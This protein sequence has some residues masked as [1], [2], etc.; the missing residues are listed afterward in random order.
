MSVACAV[1]EALE[2]SRGHKEQADLTAAQIEH[3]MPQKLREEW[4]AALGE[5][6]ARIHADWLHRPGN[7]TLSAYNQEVGNQPYAAKR[8]RF[9]ES[10]VVLTRELGQS[11]N[12]GE[13]EIRSRGEQLA[14]E[15][16]AI[17]VGPVEPYVPSET[18]DAANDY[19]AQRFAFWSGFAAYI[20]HAH[21][22]V[23]MIEPRNTREIRLSS[24]VRYISVDLRYKIQTG[25]LFIDMYFNNKRAVPVWKKLSVDPTAINLAIDDTWEFTCSPTRNWAWAT[26][27]YDV[28]SDD[29]AEWPTVFGWLG[30]KLSLLYGQ[31]FPMLHQELEDIGA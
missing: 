15:A 16:A 14:R 23:P 12:W 10:N 6:A 28:A 5:D 17:W 21:P 27:R 31:V 30:Q 8:V 11:E 3:V 26:V 20:A 9:A 19:R 7:L 22:E 18:A 29:P 13:D 4:V 1:L 25:Q 2:R 24:G